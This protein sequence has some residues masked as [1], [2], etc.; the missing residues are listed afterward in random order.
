[1]VLDLGDMYHYYIMYVEVTWL[2]HIL[3]FIFP[4]LVLLLLLLSLL[5]L[6]VHSSAPE[7]DHE[8]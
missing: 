6:F 2:L 8:W 5:L 1:M 7:S 4:N 3:V